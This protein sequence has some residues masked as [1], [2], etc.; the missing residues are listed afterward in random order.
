MTLIFLLIALLR[1]TSLILMNY[2]TYCPSIF[3]LYFETTE[4][5]GSV[6]PSVWFRMAS[7][8]PVLF[9]QHFDYL[10]GVLFTR[11]QVHRFDV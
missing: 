6:D 3:D 8:A 10:F 2:C 5:F 9:V 7:R 11:I 1:A 4:P